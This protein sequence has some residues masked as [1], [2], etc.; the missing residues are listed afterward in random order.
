M[1]KNSLEI[2]TLN[3]SGITDFASARN[4]LLKKSKAEWVLFLDTDEKLSDELKKEISDLDPKNCNGF[5]IKRKIVF[6]GREIGEDHV[7]RLARRDFG[8][9]VR[10][11]HETWE[12]RGRIG[13]LNG[14]IIHNTASGLYDYI[15]KMNKYSSIHAAENIRE[16]KYS[17][18]FKMIFYPKLKF[19]QNI[20]AGRGFVF[21]MLQSF[22]SFLGWTK[23]WE[24]QKD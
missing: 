4:L 11:V 23:Q 14:Y 21:S 20:L 17:N 5:V 8:R 24:L 1:T 2:V 16:G 12:V 6:L 22:H 3:K 7:L 15:E 10:K 13:T 9:W 19:I 18:I